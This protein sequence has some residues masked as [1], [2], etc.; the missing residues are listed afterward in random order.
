MIYCIYRHQ[1]YTKYRERRTDVKLDLK[2]EIKV[3]KL[4]SIKAVVDLLFI[5]PRTV[6]PAFGGEKGGKICS[7]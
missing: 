4:L 6:C 5:S 2:E 1:P 7:H 3:N